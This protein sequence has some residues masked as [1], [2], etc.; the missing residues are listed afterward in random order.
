M[1]LLIRVLTKSC[2]LSEHDRDLMISES[3]RSGSGVDIMING[4]R[5]YPSISIDGHA[6]AELVP[7]IVVGG[8]HFNSPAMV[9][10]VSQKSR[11]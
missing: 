10:M 3:S 6:V 4:A 2:F 8:A 1:G 7:S 5:G 11:G 9:T